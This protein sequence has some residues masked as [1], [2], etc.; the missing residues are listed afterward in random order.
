MSSKKDVIIVGGGVIGCSIAYQLAKRGITSLILER[1]SIGARASGKAWA[2]I[3]YPGVLLMA[4]QA[5]NTLFYMPEGESATNFMDLFVLGYYHMADLALDIK[6]I[7]GIDIEYAEGE[8][9]YLVKTKDEESLIKSVLPFMRSQGYTEVDWIP[10][11]DLRTIF[12]NINP[13]FLGGINTPELQ[14]E[15][16]KYTLGLAQAAEKMDCEVKQG[17][18]VGF[19]TSGGRVTSVKLASGAEIEADKVVIAMGPW[20]GQGTSWLGKEIPIQLQMEECLR[21]EGSGNLPLHYLTNGTQTIVPRVNGEIIVGSAGHFNLKDEFDSSLS[22]EK[23]MSLLEGVLDMLPDI[24]EA[25]LIEHRGDL[26]A[27]GPAPTYNKPVMG[28]LPEYENCY[29]ATR[30]GTLGIMMSPGVGK[31][32]ADLIT[33]ERIPRRFR[34]MLNYLSPI[35]ALQ[36]KA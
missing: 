9:T 31:V 27:W 1:D 24:E 34:R 36:N 21:M 8:S 29:V 4:D 15:P 13:K 19:G 22:E 35:R 20:A 17:E 18:A 14:V 30:F 32:M 16:Y 12:P 28:L 6:K 26:Q 25:K 3:S 33:G 2:V 7:G 23:K 5:E 11:S 10:K